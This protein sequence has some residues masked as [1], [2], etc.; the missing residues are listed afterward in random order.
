M[1]ACL[2]QLCLA[3][4][5]G[6]HQGS[7]PP[8]LSAVAALTDYVYSVVVK[9]CYKPQ[10]CLLWHKLCLTCS[11]WSCLLGTS[12]KACFSLLLCSSLTDV[13]MM[14]VEVCVHS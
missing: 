9:S 1:H 2:H 3:S 7:T 8:D 10:C 4:P 14:A 5:D 11:C 6:H 13:D 12:C